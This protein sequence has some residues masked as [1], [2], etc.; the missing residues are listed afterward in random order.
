[1]ACEL[2]RKSVKKKDLQ[3]YIGKKKAGGKGPIP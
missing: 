1:M 2:Y 3:V